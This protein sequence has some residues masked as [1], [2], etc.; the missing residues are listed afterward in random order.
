[1][2][3]PKLSQKESLH[4]ERQLASGGLCENQKFSSVP[5]VFSIELR[6]EAGTA[7]PKA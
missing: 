3:H 7:G 4:Q 2:L 1:M 5:N 6:F